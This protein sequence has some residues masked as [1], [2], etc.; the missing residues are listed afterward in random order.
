MK[1]MSEHNLAIN[2]N[3]VAEVA[4]VSKTW[5][6]QHPKISAKIKKHRIGTN[7]ISYESL[8]NKYEKT[9][10]ENETLKRKNTLLKEQVQSLKQQLETVYGELHKIKM[11]S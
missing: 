4:G 6:Y 11:K 7:C 9:I 1:Y 2:F 5:L 8:N 3:S 10:V